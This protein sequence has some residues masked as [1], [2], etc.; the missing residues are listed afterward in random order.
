MKLPD[1]ELLLLIKQMNGATS[2]HSFCGLE[3]IN[4]Q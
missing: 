3:P 2:T 4:F 1:S